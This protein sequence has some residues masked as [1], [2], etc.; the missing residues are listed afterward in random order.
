MKRI[1][2]MS[3]RPKRKSEWRP[4]LNESQWRSRYRSMAVWYVRKAERMRSD[5]YQ[6]WAVFTVL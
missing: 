1:Y 2:L 3:V 4:M 6:Q 5:N